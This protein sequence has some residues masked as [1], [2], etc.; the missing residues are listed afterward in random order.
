MKQFL[1]IGLCLTT[2]QAQVATSIAPERPQ[3]PI[4]IR[5]YL[6]PEVPPI[7]TTDSPRLNSLIRAGT[8]YLTAADAV[9]L[10]LENNV[11]IEISRYNPILGEWRVERAQAGGALPGVPSGA[12]QVGSVASGQGVAGSQAAAGVG[13]GGATSTAQRT[14]AQISQIGPVTQNLD[15]TIQESSVFSHT[16]T[17]QANATQSLTSSLIANTRVHSVSV[18]QGFLT[19]GSVTLNFRNNYLNENSP[20]DLLNPSVAPNLSISFQ[21]NLLRGFG[22]A[23][24][25]RT[26]TVAKKNLA[27]TDLNFRNQVIGIITQVLNSYYA[28]S[29]AYQDVKAKQVAVDVAQTLFS[30]LKKQVDIGS[31]APPELIRSEA[32]VVDSRLTLANAQTTLDQQ[33]VRLK[34]LISRNLL[35]GVHIL[36]V[37]KIDIPAMDEFPPLEQMVSEAQKNRTDLLVSSAN[38][39][40]SEINALGTRNGILPN[41]QVFGAESQAG[42][43]GTP[44]PGKNP[45]P[46]FVGG[47]GKA[48]GQVFRRNFPTERIGVFGQVP[49]GNNQAQADFGI[50]QLQLRQ[51][52]LASR[53]SFNQVE[54]SLQNAVIGIRQARARYDAA[55]RNRVLQ[56]ELLTAEQKR[57]ALD[58][59]TP[60]AVIQ[61]QRDLTTAQS[62]E[63]QAL[64]SY[65]E[66]RVTLNQTLGRTLEAN[67][68]NMV[69]VK[70]GSGFQKK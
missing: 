48:T 21:H 59:S 24:N 54:V 67:H 63:T 66:A 35:N 11:D 4:I 46:Y 32:Q 14:N 28:L 55:V 47:L 5:P 49:I 38:L 58:A 15:P 2:L 12:S 51:S 25:A 42:L 62:A 16:T 3:A 44:N 36:P 22:I 1:A 10:A 56:Q 65:S 69:E 31:I 18:T 40:T 68:V 8:L 23:V 27:I 30:D 33:E 50:D 37:D 19:G 7:R 41:V 13:G 45:D 26:I 9:A 20:S 43:G 34:S 29:A 64:V 17:P 57:F 60:S 70:L 39:E 53:K 6:A 61:Q 52:Q